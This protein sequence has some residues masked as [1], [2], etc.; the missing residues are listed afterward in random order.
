MGYGLSA[1]F[2]S[3][4]H[5]I[6][7]LGNGVVNSEAVWYPGKVGGLAGRVVIKCSISC[8]PTKRH[9][10][11]LMAEGEVYAWGNGS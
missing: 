10:L 1:N 8:A 3:V 11:A 6:G 7:E 5:L 4:S 9:A 2:T